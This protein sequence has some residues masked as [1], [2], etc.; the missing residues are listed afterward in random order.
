VIGLGRKDVPQAASAE[1]PT[2]Q[3]FV[4]S[5]NEVLRYDG[6]TGAFLNIFVAAGNGGLSD[7][8]GLRFGPDCHLYVISSGLKMILR[9]DGQTGAFR[10]TFVAPGSGGLDSPRGLVFGPD[11]HLYVSSSGTHAILRYE[12]QTGAFLNPLW[13]RVVEG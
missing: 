1:L 7:P 4:S 13:R 12:R 2:S 8:T 11:G 6:Q 9:Y 10:K 5:A 3:L